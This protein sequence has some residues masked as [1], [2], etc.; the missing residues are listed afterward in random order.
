MSFIEID[1][2]NQKITNVSILYINDD[3]CVISTK[4]YVD[5]IDY[6]LD[7]EKKI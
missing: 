7:P 1:I 6:L 5:N 2:L 3:Y 4:N